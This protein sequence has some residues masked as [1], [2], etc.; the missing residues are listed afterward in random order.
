[1]PTIEQ[2]KELRAITGISISECKKALEEA[3]NDPEKAKAL[4]RERGKEIAEKKGVR[5]TGE[6]L[7][8]SYVHGNGKI[9]SMVQV[10]CET[11]FVARS[12]DFQA[13]CHELALQV[14]S[15]EADSIEDLLAQEYIKDTSTT[16]KDIIQEVIAKVGENIVVDKFTRFSM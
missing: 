11:D 3:G 16:I 1:M 15:M 8:V 10:R 2:I 4:L 13:L 9:G 12:Q 5:E 14:A 7:V 6:G